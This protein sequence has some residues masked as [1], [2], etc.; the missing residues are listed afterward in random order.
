M[1][2][3]SAPCKDPIDAAHR[4]CYI[5]EMRTAHCAVKRFAVIVAVLLEST[6]PG[7]T[8]QSP[9]T[10]ASAVQA[11]EL[12]ETG[13]RALDSRRFREAVTMLERSAALVPQVETYFLLGRAYWGEDRP[14][15]ISADKAIAA[16]R[17]AQELDPNLVS[18]S[19]VMAVEQVAVAAVRN[20]RL[21][22]ARAAFARLAAV[23]SDPA[24]LAR[25]RTQIDEIDL[26]RGVYRPPLR[27]NYNDRGEV[28]GP[29]GPL[30][31]RTN[32]NFEK[33]RH[34]SDPV[35]AEGH[36]RRAVETDPT[37]HQAYLNLAQ[38]L[39]QQHRCGDAV[40]YL[41]K[42][43]RVWRLNNPDGPPYVRALVALV[44]CHLLLGSLDEAAANQKV[45]DAIPGQD[46][47]EVLTGLQVRIASGRA[48]ETIAILEAGARDDPENVDV[49][50]VLAAAYAAD[51]RYADAAARL[52]TAIEAVP[53]GNLILTPLI[54]RWNALRDDWR[55]Q[56]ATP[57]GS[58]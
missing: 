21:D 57:K 15:P 31:M 35:R 51:G 47:W 7:I 38:S 14:Y 26:D 3:E 41:E 30:G 16:F 18:S 13:R 24:R 8:R 39:I 20:E 33:G 25:F 10:P 11:R 48:A 29:V 27:T 2:S 55:R 45:L 49:L 1:R 46:N 23:E 54:P 5:R 44:K 58:R 36:F 40:P 34:T 17:R 53:P 28:L 50:H 19:A 42:A 4:I 9:P 56:A 32:R 12:L 43:D 37:M 22:E 52:Q 6:A